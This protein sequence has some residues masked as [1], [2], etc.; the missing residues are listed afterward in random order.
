MPSK[1]EKCA[2][3]ADGMTRRKKRILM[4]P[5]RMNDRGSWGCHKMTCTGSWSWLCCLKRSKAKLHVK[6]KS[7]RKERPPEGSGRLL[8]ASLLNDGLKPVATILRMEGGKVRGTTITKWQ[9]SSFRQTAD[10]GTH[11]VRRSREKGTV[12][13]SIRLNSDSLEGPEGTELAHSRI[14]P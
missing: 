1:A 6:K 10:D 8:K 13:L 4:D 7:Q 12:R 14:Q 9:P 5:A 11:H 2:P 3:S